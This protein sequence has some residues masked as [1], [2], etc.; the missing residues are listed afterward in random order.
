MI[1]V[2]ALVV[3]V[4]IAFFSPRWIFGIQDRKQYNNLVLN[5]REN[6]DVAVLSTNYETSFY[7]R[8]VNFAENQ[9]NQAN[10]YVT[11]EELTDYEELQNFLYS[12]NGL[13]RTEIAVLMDIDLITSDIYECEISK[14]KQYIVYSDDYTKGVNF[15]LWYIELEHPDEE[16]G[17]YK[18]LLE[19][20]TGEFYGLQADTGGVAVKGYANKE[21]GS[22]SAPITLE[23]CLGLT[24]MSDYYEA[25]YSIAY[26]FGG[27]AE[28]EAF[29][30]YY[31]M[32]YVNLL[33]WYDVTAR[34]SG[35]NVYDS[36]SGFGNAQ[37]DYP[38]SMA[39]TNEIIQMLRENQIAENED[40]LKWENFIKQNPPMVVT[41]NEGNMLDSVFPYE[42]GRLT[43]RMETTENIT[44][45]WI[46]HD[47]T[48]GFPA[49][50]S[51][52]PEFN[53]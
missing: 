31:Q 1:S 3:L 48:V 10:F 45:P 2:L 37:V 14:W 53:E 49:I 22:G 12:G 17:T 18:L 34:K 33:N 29:F 32:F 44:Y 8:M 39:V 35:I 27:L 9:T 21:G 38:E 25:W 41:Q 26:R 6:I 7:R 24:T 23:R 16:I 50:Y 28:N 47:I 36:G 40:Q 43:F 13:N 42:D 19:A 52:I 30:D 4:G 5:E 11:S 15:I 46:L 20:N 51:L